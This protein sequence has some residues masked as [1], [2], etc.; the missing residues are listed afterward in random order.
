MRRTFYAC[1]IPTTPTNYEQMQMHRSSPSS[2]NFGALWSI[3]VE[4]SS[5]VLLRAF[6][7]HFILIRLRAHE[8]RSIWFRSDCILP[9]ERMFNLPWCF[10][11]LMLDRVL[12]IILGVHATTDRSEDISTN[13]SV[14]ISK[15]S[16]RRDFP[17][18][19][20]TQSWKIVYRKTK[21]GSFGGRICGYLSQ[22]RLRARV[23]IDEMSIE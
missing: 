8:F 23:C 14:I 19:G 13:F 6:L 9:Y 11:R 21:Q 10:R 3:P 18:R 16:R 4:F 2:G 5:A 12:H 17:C 15:R 22:T 7:E 20:D 1:A